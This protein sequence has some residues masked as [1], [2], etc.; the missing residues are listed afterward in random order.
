MLRCGHPLQNVL[1]RLIAFFQVSPIGVIVLVGGAFA[2]NYLLDELL[3][4]RCVDRK[5]RERENRCPEKGA[6]PLAIGL[7]LPKNVGF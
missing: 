3:W 7:P 2:V 4:I 6:L 1:F 5:K